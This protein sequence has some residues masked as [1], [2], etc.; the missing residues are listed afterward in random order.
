MPIRGSS[1]FAN[2]EGNAVPSGNQ[3]EAEVL[4]W[5]LAVQNDKRRQNPPATNGPALREMGE[6]QINGLMS[7]HDRL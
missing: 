6:F 5:D 2:R 3:A 4:S 7:G 1:W